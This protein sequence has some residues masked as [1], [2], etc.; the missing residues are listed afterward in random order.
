MFIYQ[1]ANNN[2]SQIGCQ[3]CILLTAISETS[4]P[5]Y[6]GVAESPDYLLIQ[7]FYYL[8]DFK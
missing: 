4:L 1:N 7:S 6:N 5:S 2:K 8:T 3:V